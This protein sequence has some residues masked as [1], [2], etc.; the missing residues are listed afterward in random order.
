MK[1]ITI[2]SAIALAV[3]VTSCQKEAVRQPSGN[4][5]PGNPAVST[6][7]KQTIISSWFI[8]PLSLVS[9]RNET[10]LMGK[11]SFGQHVEYD[12]TQHVELAYISMPGERRPVIRRLPMKL[13]IESGVQ[14][15]IFDVQ[16]ALDNTG[17]ILTVKNTNPGSIAADAGIFSDFHYRY[18]VIPKEVYDSFQIDWDNY[19]EVAQA[20]NL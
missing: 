1:K 18:I 19:R 9:D 13:K 10:Y 16:F 8:L 20:L 2:L 3:F 4:P 5:A 11:E 14:D 7:A 6:A 17:F 15:E 12:K